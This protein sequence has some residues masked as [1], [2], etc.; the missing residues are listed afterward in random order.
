VVVFVFGVDR[1]YDAGGVW[2][3]GPGRDVEEAGGVEGRGLLHERDLGCV[4]RGGQAE[5]GALVVLEPLFLG[6]DEV[7][8]DAEICLGGLGVEL[9]QH[10]LEFVCV[11]AISVCEEGVHFLQGKV[12]SPSSHGRD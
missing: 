5:L 9:D 2:T 7:L 12:L 8:L 6:L 3:G 4:A 11:F 10:A 1:R